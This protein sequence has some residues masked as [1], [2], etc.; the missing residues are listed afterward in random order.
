MS[1]KVWLVGPD[2]GEL[3]ITQGPIFV[4][5]EASWNHWDCEPSREAA[6]NQAYLRLLRGPTD[7]SPEAPRQQLLF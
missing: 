5:G 1:D 4:V 6:A 3:K 7:K 2:G